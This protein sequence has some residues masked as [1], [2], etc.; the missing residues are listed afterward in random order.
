MGALK[1]CTRHKAVVSFDV[2]RILLSW[3]SSDRIIKV[4]FNGLLG[5]GNIFPCFAWGLFDAFITKILPI[6]YRMS[7]VCRIMWDYRKDQK[8]ASFGKKVA[9]E[10]DYDIRNFD[11]CLK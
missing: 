1:H 6:L 4:S 5:V 10:N 2:G 9:L 8:N 11:Q 3:R 7:V